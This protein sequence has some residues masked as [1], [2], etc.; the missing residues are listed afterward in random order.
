MHFCQIVFFIYAGMIKKLFKQKSASALDYEN[1]H[2]G[3]IAQQATV[4]AAKA[5][6]QQRYVSAPFSGKLG[7]IQPHVGMYI[8][9]GA[10]VVTLENRN[11]L[12][13]D[14]QLP[15]SLSNRVHV[16]DTVQIVSKLA[17]RNQVLKAKITAANPGL[18][19]SRNRVYR[20]HVINPPSWLTPGSYCKTLVKI[21]KPFETIILPRSAIQSSTGGD[22]VW[23]VHANKTIS[24]RAIDTGD[25]LASGSV[26]VK[27]GLSPAEEVVMLGGFKLYEGQTI[28][29]QPYKAK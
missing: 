13:V 23:V 28:N 11:V 5:R 15:Q 24:S 6:L 26:V 19:S 1:A 22:R 12:W 3:F 2:Q 21:G 27:Q 29:P 14:F 17:P 8:S 16:G 20:G 18:T 9:P 7:V 10:A 4:A 25:T